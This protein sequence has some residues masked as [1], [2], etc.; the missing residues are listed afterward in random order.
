MNVLRAWY[1]SATFFLA[2]GLQGGIGHSKWVPLN[3]CLTGFIMGAGQ[4]E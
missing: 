4:S 3:A 1:F 2:S